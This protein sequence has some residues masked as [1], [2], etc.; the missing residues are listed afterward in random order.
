VRKRKK[1]K[2]QSGMVG[3]TGG[4]FR[5]PPGSEPRADLPAWGSRK[6]QAVVRPQNFAFYRGIDTLYKFRAFTSKKDE[7][8]VR[9]IIEHHTVYFSPPDK[10]NDL[11]DMAVLHKI[12]GDKTKPATRRRVLRD[13]E[14][15]M[16]QHTP[17]LMENVIRK[18]LDCARTADLGALEQQ[19]SEQ[20]QARLAREFPVF[21][22]SSDNTRP[23]QWAYYAADNTGLCIHFDSRIQSRSPFAFARTVEYQDKR[24]SLPIP[25]VLDNTEVARRV[26]LIKHTD[27]KHEREY[28]VL[29]HSGIE[30]NFKS[31]DGSKAEFAAPL[32]LGITVGNRMSK[33]RVAVI[34]KM[35]SAHTPEIP[36][37]RANPRR[38]TFTCSI[39]PL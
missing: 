10:L 29:G 13:L 35:A 24:P 25:L 21:C 22:L 1:K 7:S 15:L 37:F 16:R 11:F 2:K 32:I 6:W 8:R 38:E 9:E 30:Q 4:R 23:A 26:A 17:A 12:T 5:L 19:A 39:D 18:Q 36:L 3:Q 27:W 33:E 31:F 14:R 20:S 28:R 34:R